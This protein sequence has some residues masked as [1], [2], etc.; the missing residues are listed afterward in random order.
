M[1]HDQVL[2]IDSWN[3]ARRAAEAAPAEGGSRESRLDQARRRDVLQRVQE[4]LIERTRQQMA[5]PARPLAAT[6]APRVIVVHRNEWFRG[7]VASALRDAGVHV[8]CALENGADAVGAAIAEQPDLVLLEDRLPMIGASE[9][10]RWLT[11]HAP[12][13]ICAVQVARDHDLGTFLDAGART[14]FSRRVPPVDV[15]EE[16]AG[17]LAVGQF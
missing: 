6:A 9:V 1:L 3:A 4:T 12:H 5:D 7:K 10:I 11:E 15:A 17:L 13:T 8:V 14:A 16:L 2:G